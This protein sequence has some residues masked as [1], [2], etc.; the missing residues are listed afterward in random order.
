M[1]P[2]AE[3]HRGAIVEPGARIPASCRV[4]PFCYVSAEVE[5]GE[6]CE[7]ISHVV[8]HGPSRI[9]SHNRF[10]PFASIGLPPQDLKFA[11]EKTRLEMGDHNT[12]R[13][14]VTIHRG[15]AGGGGV[16]RIGNHTLIMAYAH[17]AHD[18]LIGDHAI[19]ANA[20]TLGGHVTVEEW[21]VVG[22]LCPV[23]QFV[24]IG[25]YSYIGGGT[26]ITQDVLP[27]SKTVA[28]RDTHAYGLNATGLQR[29]GFS[30][31]RIRKIHHAFKVLLA[32]KLNTSQALEKLKAEPQAGEDVALLIRFIE[33]SQR[34][35]IK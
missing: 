28:A 22:A 13:E 16:T 29:R 25:A 32:S 17:I 19:L 33:A 15:T 21:A 9:G 35:V 5:L 4:G 6:H 14:C 1:I 10:F 23:H 2:G 11:G 7:L 12:V 24:R 26:T 8:I 3:I 31:E 27:F 18:C 30:R 34:G 20:A